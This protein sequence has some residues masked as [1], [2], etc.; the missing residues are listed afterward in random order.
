[1]I[2]NK[3]KQARQLHFNPIAFGVILI[4]VITGYFLWQTFNDTNKIKLLEKKLEK[5]KEEAGKININTVSAEEVYQW[6]GNKNIELIDIRNPDE[7]KIKHIESSIN[8][9]LNDLIK[10]LKKI[11]SS[12]KII[13]I[14]KEN[15]KKGQILTEH[16]SNENVET[17]YL[18]GGILEYARQNYPL[19]ATGDPT[20]VTDQIKAP[21]I[22]AEQVRKEMLQGKV[23]S[24][25]DVRPT[26][27]FQL[28]NIT[29]SKNISLKDIENSK[30]LLP[31]R[32]I[33]LYDADPTRSFRAGVKLYDMGISNFY[34][35]SDTFGV[36]KNILL[37]ENN[38]KQKLDEQK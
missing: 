29:G 7:Y 28:N 1:M 11:D 36:L 2:Q 14:A 34:S 18:E 31:S 17:R 22:T 8:L 12:K 23:F 16:L 10:S 9:P 32:T 4:V 27:A 25:I 33:L 5:E 38:T 35:C 20:N 6:I 37:T 13:I 19:I 26:G 21:L 3:K 24:F 30:N 15:D